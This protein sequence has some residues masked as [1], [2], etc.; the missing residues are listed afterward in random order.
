MTTVSITVFA[1]LVGIFIGAAAVFVSLSPKLESLGTVARITGAVAIITAGA[2]LLL[3][4]LFMPL[5]GPS[6]LAL[7][8]AGV[9]IVAIS[10]WRWWL[11]WIPLP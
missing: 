2:I 3:P 7:S 6:G 4:V 5:L 11:L 1:G 9:V 10:A 8:L